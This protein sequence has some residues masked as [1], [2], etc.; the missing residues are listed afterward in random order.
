MEAGTA[1]GWEEQSFDV[2]AGATGG[3]ASFEVRFSAA[4]ATFHYWL[5]SPG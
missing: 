5:V 4:V 1:D 3:R 2:P